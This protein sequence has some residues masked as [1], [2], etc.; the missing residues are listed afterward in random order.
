MPARPRPILLQDPVEQQLVASGVVPA[1]QIPL[2]IQ[3]RTFV[4]APTLMAT[5]PTW[6]WG[7]MPGM[8]MTGDLWM[9]HCLY[10]GPEPGRY[11][12]SQSVWSMALRSVVLAADQE[13]HPWP[14]A[15]PVLRSHQRALGAVRKPRRTA[16]LDGHGSLHGHPGRQRYSLS[17]GN[18]RTEGIP[19][20]EFSTLQMTAFWNLQMY[21]A[22]STVT[23][24]D[25]RTDTEVKMVPASP[26][27]G[28]PANWPTDGRVGGVPDPT[29]AWS[30]LDP[31]RY[32]GWLPACTRRRSQPAGCLEHGPDDVQFWKR[33]GPLA[34]A[35]LRGAGRCH[36]RFLEVCGQ[37]PDH[38]QRRARSIPGARS[39]IGLLH[40][41]PGHDGHGRC[42]HTATGLRSPTRG[43]SCRS[44]S[45]PPDRTGRPSSL[46]T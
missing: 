44:R 41:C 14:R 5:D 28:L 26:N 46:T 39:A 21:V 16:S 42:S 18:R 27:T 1:D 45:L 12:R 43:P 10:D 7:T 8:P 6:N 23:T 3:D 13:H 35:G 19:L 33:F 9:P 29:T 32:R 20:S 37:D 38:L 36:R 15:E 11:E 24:A 17:Y 30:R 25:G 40:G 4:S 22:D 2:V 31:D 34:P